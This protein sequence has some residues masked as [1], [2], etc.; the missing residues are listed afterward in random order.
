MSGEVPLNSE[1]LEKRAARFNSL[2]RTKANKNGNMTTTVTFSNTSM[3]GVMED[4]SGDFELGDYHVVGVCQEIEKPYLRLTAVSVVLNDT[5]SIRSLIFLVATGILILS[6]TLV[7]IMFKVLMHVARF[8]ERLTR[9][10]WTY[11]FV[12]HVSKVSL[13]H[14]NL[15]ASLYI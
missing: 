12:L 14:A 5:L 9:L 2:R 1:L 10:C 13:Y 7:P 6:L 8:L 11:N 15:A 3:L 4:T